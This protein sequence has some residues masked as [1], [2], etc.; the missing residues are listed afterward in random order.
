MAHLHPRTPYRQD[1]SATNRTWLPSDTP[2]TWGELRTEPRDTSLSDNIGCCQSWVEHRE[3]SSR[4]T[5]I[6][7]TFKTCCKQQNKKAESSRQKDVSH[8]ECSVRMT[9]MSYCASPDYTALPG[10]HETFRSFFTHDVHVNWNL[11]FVVFSLLVADVSKH[12]LCPI[13]IG[14]VSSKKTYERSL[15][16]GQL[17]QTRFRGD[18]QPQRY[19]K[20]NFCNSHALDCHISIAICKA[21]KYCD[22]SYVNQVLLLISSPQSKKDLIRALTS[23]YMPAIHH[24]MVGYQKTV[25]AASMHP[26]FLRNWFHVGWKHVSETC[27]SK[28]LYSSKGKFILQ[29]QKYT[30]LTYFKQLWINTLASDA[31]WLPGHWCQPFMVPFC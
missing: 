9:K 11:I 29:W 25:Q 24:V 14:R 2:V 27:S 22:T 20:K 16:R 19:I 28:Y 3:N 6:I 18:G 30:S 8:N 26:E 1:T 23:N 10:A 17:Q 5:C 12:S 31:S 15:Y 21:A 4:T 7:S 13:F